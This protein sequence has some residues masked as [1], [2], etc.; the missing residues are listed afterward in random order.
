VTIPAEQVEWFP[1]GVR[2]SLRHDGLG[3]LHEHVLHGEVYDASAFA[4][5]PLMSGQIVTIERGPHAY[6]RMLT[7]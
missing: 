1:E 4:R 6:L 3:G 2:D 7:T 5:P